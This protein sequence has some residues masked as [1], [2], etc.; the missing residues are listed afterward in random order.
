MALKANVHFL[1]Y[2]C[3]LSVQSAYHFKFSDGSYG[4]RQVANMKFSWIIP[5]PKQ[6]RML[7]LLITDCIRPNNNID[8]LCSIKLNLLSVAE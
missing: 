8:R 3:L 7:Q 6:G 5:G 2:L 1:M 4:T